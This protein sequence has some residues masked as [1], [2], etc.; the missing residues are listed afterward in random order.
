MSCIS[1]GP[2]GQLLRVPRD[3]DGYPPS[4]HSVRRTYISQIQTGFERNSLLQVPQPSHQRYRITSYLRLAHATILAIHRWAEF[5]MHAAKN[6][7][8]MDGQLRMVKGT[9]SEMSQST[10]IHCLRYLE[11]KG[12]L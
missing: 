6:L 2:D 8:G 4:G 5:A 12:C 7:R 9:P 10:Q 3:S 11:L 1:G